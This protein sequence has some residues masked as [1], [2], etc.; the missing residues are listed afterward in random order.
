MFVGHCIQH[1]LS[2]WG[3]RSSSIDIG[4]AG[5]IIIIIIVNFT[6]MGAVRLLWQ[7]EDEQDEYIRYYQ[8]KKAKR[9]L[10]ETSQLSEI[11]QVSDISQ[12]Q[13]SPS[14]ER[15]PSC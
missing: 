3:L 2:V 10:S 6:D 14:C 12:C 15:S 4:I 1:I 9:N 11:S 8:E 13:R 5:I 7:K